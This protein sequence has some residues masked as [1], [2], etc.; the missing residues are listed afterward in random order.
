MKEDENFWHTQRPLTSEMLQYA[1]QDA[2]FLPAVYEK[3]Q[4][5]FTIPYI[6]RS[7][8]PSGEPVFQ[9]MTVLDK[10]LA[11]SKK[12]REYA[13][14]NT[15]VKDFREMQIGREIVAFIKNYR[16]DVIYCSLN[17]GVS[18]VIRDPDSRKTLEKYNSFGDL[19]YVT[20]VGIEGP[21]NQ[22]QLTFSRQF[23]ETSVA[24]VKVRPEDKPWGMMQ[25]QNPLMPFMQNIY[26]QVFHQINMF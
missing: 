21:K 9:T 4:E 5:Y 2:L 7:S 26:P 17:I 24:P 15:D 8:S 14:I 20:H 25:P 22:L 12:C 16:R 23:T 11:D 19:V 18:G 3:M 1:A 10:I 6:D 13:R